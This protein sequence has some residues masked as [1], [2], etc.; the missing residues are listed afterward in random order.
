MPTPKPPVYRISI[1]CPDFTIAE[2]V[3][4][5]FADLGYGTGFRRY[6]NTLKNLE[7]F[8]AD[9]FTHTPPD[10]MDI[11]ARMHTISTVWGDVFSLNINRIS[12]TDWIGKNQ[13]D[14]QPISIGNFFIYQPLYTGDIPTD[15]IPILVRADQAF[16]TGSHYTTAGCLQAIED[17]KLPANPKILDIG[18]GT[19]ILAVGAAKI[20]N[21]SV[22]A[23]DIDKKSVAVATDLVQKNQVPVQV[24]HSDG[25]KNPVIQTHA[26]YDMLIA[27]ILANPLRHM[28]QSFVY[29]TAPNGY[30]IVSGFTICQQNDI[31]SIYEQLGCVLVQSYTDNDWVTLRYQL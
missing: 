30:I 7:K 26:P 17:T 20:F 19:G 4:D 5:F 9:I 28:A 2:L 10:N 6:D 29:I 27:N 13:Q 22:I 14:S 24:I 16:G 18:T 8:Y 25:V 23:C 1:L 3:S 21:T 15:K 31:R 12:D 11:T